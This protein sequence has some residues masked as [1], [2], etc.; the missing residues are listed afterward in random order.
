[1]RIG[2][3]GFIVEVELFPNT[4]SGYVMIFL[5]RCMFV[6]SAAVLLIVTTAVG[7]AAA[8]YSESSRDTVQ[9]LNGRVYAIAVQGDRVYLGGTFTSVRDPAT[10]NSVNRA[11]MVA[12]ERS[13][14]A[15]V[16]AFSPSVNDDVRAI[17]V[18]AD[19]NRIYLGGTFSNVNGTSRTRL[20]AVDRNGS[21]VP[22]WDPDANSGVRDLVLQGDSMFVAGVFGRVDGLRRQGLAKLSAATGDVDTGWTANTSEGRAHA[23]A[24]SADGSRLY[25]GG[26]FRGVDGQP[27]DFL[28]SVST[29]TGNVTSWTPPEA[30]STCRV[31]DLAVNGDDVYGAVGGP[32]G[33]TVSWDATNNVRNWAVTADGDVQAVAYHDGVVYAGGHFGPT[34]DHSPRHQLAAVQAS[35]GN[36]LP[37][38]PPFTGADSP[39]T[40][41]LVADSDYL[42]VGGAFRGIQTGPQRRYAEF[43]FQ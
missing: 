11:R 31:L 21:V 26:P 15:L 1:M 9:V 6:L 12:V 8:A 4:L 27:R 42:R 5:R 22:G 16:Q 25:V 20:A 28:A 23:A 7:P 40:W 38:S 41:A 18:S 2:F 37:F 3:T 36:L 19:G 33:R 13:T 29:S 17:A 35:N 32:G 24:L 14:G 34:F 43:P 10:G 39:G 30:C